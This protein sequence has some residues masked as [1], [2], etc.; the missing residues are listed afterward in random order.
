VATVRIH[1][2]KKQSI[3]LILVNKLNEERA[4]LLGAKKYLDVD[5][6]EL[7]PDCYNKAEK[8][9]LKLEVRKIG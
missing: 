7:T 9:I 8:G 3:P 1:N 5:S 2:R 6:S 4:E